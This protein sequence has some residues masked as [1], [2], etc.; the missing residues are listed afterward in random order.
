LRARC[1]GR[2]P[3]NAL[4]ASVGTYATRST[5]RVRGAFGGP[6]EDSVVNDQELGPYRIVAKLGA[7]GMGDVERFQPPRP[8]DGSIWM[9]DNVD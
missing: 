9:L 5:P 6:V 3:D 8:G 7:G 1:L 2:N 4:L